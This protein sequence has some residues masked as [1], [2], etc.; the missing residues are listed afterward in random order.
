MVHALP[1]AIAT[2][3][4]H[5]FNSQTWF[6][7]FDLPSADTPFVAATPI[8]AGETVEC[9]GYRVT[10]MAVRHTVP[11]VSFHVDDGRSSVVMCA[12]T[13]GGDVFR[14]MPKSASPLRAVFLESSFPNR[15]GEF[16]ALTGHLTPQL[17]GREC[18]ALPPDVEVLVTHMKPGFEQELAREIADLRR[19]GVRPC[20]DG[21]V[22]EF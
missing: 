17:L 5:L 6:C 2:L 16:A 11:A 12:D 10:A 22:F 15:M 13:G 20:R 3:R 1:E 18:A 8:R 4:D 21:D 19:P 14:E 7:A 9:E